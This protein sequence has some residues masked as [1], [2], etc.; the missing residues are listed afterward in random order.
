MPLGFCCLDLKLSARMLIKYPGLTAIGGLTMAFAIA[1]GAA[2]FEFAGQLLRPRIPLPEGDR[3]VGLRNWDAEAGREERRALHDFVTWREQLQGVEDIGAFRTVERNITTPTGG[4]HPIQVAEISASAFQLVRVAP[5]L[6]RALTESDERSGAPPVMVIG[7]DVWQTQ[8]GGDVS[9]LGRMVRLGREER[10]LVG[11]MPEGFAFPVSHSVWVPFQLN[12][13]QVGRREGP[14]IRVFARLAPG[15]SLLEARTAVATIGRRMA[16]TYPDTHKHLRPEVLPYGNLILDTSEVS[17]GLAAFKAFL[18]MFLMLVSIN[19]ATLLFARAVTRQTE[20]AVRSALGASRRRIVMQ[21]FA[22]ALVLSGL[23]A[24]AGIAGAAFALEWWLAVAEM[25]AG[26]RL[27]FW[28]TGRLSP[29]TML[30]AAGLAVIAAV[31]AGVLPALRVT[32]RNVEARLRQAFAGEARLRFGGLWT[33]VIVTQVAV[34]VAFPAS[35]FFAREYVVEIQSLDVGFPAG[36]YLSARLEHDDDGGAGGPGGTPPHAA[37]RL[38]GAYGEL[39]RR[40]SIEPGVHGVTFADRL[41]RT[42]HPHRRIEVDGDERDPAPA[43]GRHR[44]SI[45]S[46]ALN[47]FE[48]FG[49]PILAGRGFRPADLR[50]DARAVIVN[51]SFVE[52]V[53]AGRNP[54]GRRVRFVTSR[55]AGDGAMILEPGPWYQIV[56]LVRDLGILH[57][58]PRD[59]VGLYH[60]AAA[61]TMSPL[62]L[63]VHVPGDAQAFAPRLRTLAAGV[64]PTMQVHD[65]VRLDQ[66]GAAMWLELQFLFRLL[67]IMS[68]V[69][70]LLSLA[71]IYA[72]TSFSVSRRTREIG[73]RLA[74]GASH[75]RIVATALS[76]T[77]TQ[78]SVGILFGGGLVFTLT[79]VLRDLSAAE[80]LATAAYMALMMGVCLLA[81]IVP[82]RR[83]LRVQPTEALRADG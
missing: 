62:H 61:E 3:I 20:I 32:G 53:L 83:A 80:I 27:P 22:E 16:A 23:A 4:I 43:A 45:A 35:A 38:R 67:V 77:L 69:A 51:E 70:L 65:A 68:V 59:Q 42:V 2:A 71:G 46:V 11:V 52:R 30:Y 63:A 36:A 58:D 24:V 78:V 33:A 13:L 6:G 14:E 56:G 44:T 50:A 41:P 28:L 49:A 64:D 40:L 37:A 79:R 8:F 5:F 75:R 17:L 29:V 1:A 82:V 54:V 12:I 74:L 15:V 73:I 66:V 10:T 81:C 18:I 57:D 7:Y 39:E 47:F 21:L 9:V 31:I 19:V 48:V 55:R 34:T 72:L 60:P 76:R 25:E 26:G